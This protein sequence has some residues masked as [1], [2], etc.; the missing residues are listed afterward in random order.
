MGRSF[1]SSQRRALVASAPADSRELGLPASAS[2]TLAG[3]AT[4]PVAGGPALCGFGTSRPPKSPQR[5]SCVVP[6]GGT[7]TAHLVPTIHEFQGVERLPPAESRD[8]SEISWSSRPARPGVEP[9]PKSTTGPISSVEPTQRLGA[10]SQPGCH[11][12]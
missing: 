4:C 9:P 2:S 12:S 11:D 3:Q 10:I 5:G 8:E 6:S 1:G 7:N